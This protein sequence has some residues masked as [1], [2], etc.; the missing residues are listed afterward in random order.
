MIIL[1]LIFIRLQISESEQ[2]A[3][4]LQKFNIDVNAEN[5]IGM[6]PLYSAAQYGN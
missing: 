4:V 6:S 1:M 5:E 2:V 3:A